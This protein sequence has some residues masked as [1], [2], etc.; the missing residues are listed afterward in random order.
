MVNRISIL[1]STGSIGVQTLDVARNLN[2]KVDGLAAN[3]NIDLLEK[4]AREF[5]PKIVAVK[6]E[7]RARILRDRLSDT[8]CKVVGGVEGLK[9]VASIETVETVV[10]SIVGIA[11]L[12]PTMEAI[13]HKK[14]IALANKETLVTAGHIVM[15]E[16]A[17]MGVKILRWTVNILLFSEFNG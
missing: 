5:Q 11:G 4:Q 15:S 7:E 16:A 14:N 8:D 13:K 6:D 9:M 2:I 1:G 12:I 3:K 10:T 17:R